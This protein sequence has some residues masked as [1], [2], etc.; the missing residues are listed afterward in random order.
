MIPTYRV[1]IERNAF[2]DAGISTRM[3]RICDAAGSFNLYR[4]CGRVG[5]GGVELSGVVS[6]SGVGGIPSGRRILPRCLHFGNLLLYQLLVYFENQIRVIS[7]SR[8][9]GLSFA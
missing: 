3:T 6:Q 4:R 7:N 5:G 2:D 1:G 9:I 8:P